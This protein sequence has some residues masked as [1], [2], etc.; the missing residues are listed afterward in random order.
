MECWSQDPKV[1]PRMAACINSLKA[2]ALK[3][4]S[5]ISG[6]ISLAASPDDFS[7]RDALEALLAY[8][9]TYSSELSFIRNVHIP[10]ALGEYL[11]L[12]LMLMNPFG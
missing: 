3:H 11:G 9:R 7:R 1:R 12:F 4:A 2:I 6:V 5:Q 8:E 10:M